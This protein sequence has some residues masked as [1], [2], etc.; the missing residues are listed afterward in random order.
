MTCIVGLVDKGTVYIGGDSAGVSGLSVSVR[1]DEKVFVNGPFIMGFTT[2]FRMGQLLRYKLDPPKQTV[3]MDDMKY[4]VTD[5][6]DSVAKCFADNGYGSKGH[7]GTFLVGYNSKLYMI[8][9]DFQVGIP[10][11]PYH[12]VGCGADLAL[13]A[14]HATKNKKPEDRIVAALEAASTHSGGVTPPFVIL[15]QVKAK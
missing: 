12:A 8:D 1:A 15:K 2:S 10:T 11:L 5:F 7:G 3:S 4:M 14:M 9:S 6:I 13:G